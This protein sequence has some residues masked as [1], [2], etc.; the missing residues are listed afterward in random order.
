MDLELAQTLQ[1]IIISGFMG[2]AIGNFVT[3]PIFRLPRN[4]P[5]FAKDPYCGDCN[6]I[7]TPKDLFP[8][9]SWLM[10]KGKCR[11]CGASVPGFYTLTEAFVGLLFVL[12]YLYYGFSEQFLL[13]SF[14]TTTFVMLAAMLYIDNFFSDRTFAAGL[15]LAAVYRTLIEHTVYGFGGGAF[16][17]LMAGAI[18]WKL[19]GKPMK[20]D[21]AAFPTYLRILVLAGSWLTFGQWLAILPVAAFAANGC[22]NM[23]FLQRRQPCCLFTSN[24]KRIVVLGIRAEADSVLPFNEGS[25]IHP[26]TPAD[27]CAVDHSTETAAQIDQQQLAFIQLDLAMLA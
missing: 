22:L 1:G 20:R 16:A 7:L 11:Y 21:A 3:N 14:G 4:E 8:V 15:S 17:G 26:T 23:P 6:T 2:L 13:L 27:D 19:S 24:A 9:L 10:T 5:L 18:V 12:F 25:A